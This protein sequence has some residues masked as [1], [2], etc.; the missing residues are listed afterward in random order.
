MTSHV[1]TRSRIGIVG[2]GIAGS[3]AAYFV[4][5]E[6]GAEVC[7]FE[8]AAH[9]GGRIQE[10]TIAGVMVEQGASLFHSSNRY[11][12]H[13]VEM[14]GLHQ[15]STDATGTF[16]IW[17]G[18]SF[19]L[20]SSPSALL[21]KM[22]MLLRYGP[23]LLR[24]QQLVKNMVT[25]LTQI[26]ARQEQGQAFSTPEAL[27][28]ALD[29]YTLTQQQSDK[30][31]RASNISQRFLIEFVNG[32]SRNNYGQDSSINALVNLVSLAGAGMAGG[33]LYSVREGN[34][35]VCQGLLRASNAIV[36]TD[37]RVQQITRVSD[38]NGEGWELL[39][40][41]GET[42]RFDA[43]IVAT[44]FEGAR[45][46]VDERNLS[47]TADIKRAY[48][49]THVTLVVGSL[50]PM[51]F[52]KK[53]HGEIPDDILTQENPNIP[54][55]SIGIVGNKDQPTST[56]YKL[57][58]RKPLEETILTDLFAERKQIEQWQ[59]QAYPVLTP[60]TLWPPFQL[61][62]GLYYINAMESAVSTMETEIIASRNVVNLLKQESES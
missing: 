39:L 19:D 57:F 42:E 22:K 20:T 61:S 58:S 60:T 14:L 8:A 1:Y 4:Q 55:S 45:I 47:S 17:N 2:S 49:T 53:T 41:S 7:V 26:Y 36:R 31:F 24:V 43:V 27:F 3:S 56:L 34:N 51:Y 28:K 44:P 25:R 33:S 32:A 54:F 35:H 30:Y 46:T 29:L 38:T 23:T 52:G 48:Q 59:W 13:F 37:C 10:R 11:L 5:Q 50:N 9:V 6:L 21:T 18:T 12:V 15:Q 62:K 40:D 16:G